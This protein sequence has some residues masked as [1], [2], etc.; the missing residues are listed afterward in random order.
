[1]FDGGAFGAAPTDG[2]AT[3]TQELASHNGTTAS[4]ITTSTK[5]HDGFGRLLTESDAAGNTTTTAYSDAAGHNIGQT[6]TNA[7]SHTVTTV[8]DKSRHLELSVTDANAKTTKLV[9][10][11]LGRRT[12]VWPP[13][14][15][16]P[17]GAPYLKF[18]YT[19]S[20]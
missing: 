15:S 10:D 20:D 7:L 8:F 19:V 18:S 2:L 14:S 3:A 16:L 12:E 6:V 13:N 1:L 5:T 4:Y 11:A 17:A 9:Y